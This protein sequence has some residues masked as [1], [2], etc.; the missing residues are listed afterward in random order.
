MKPSLFFAIISSLLALVTTFTPED[1]EIFRLRDEIEANEGPD[2]T[3]YGMRT[4]DLL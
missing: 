2:V 1:H 3:F 4:S